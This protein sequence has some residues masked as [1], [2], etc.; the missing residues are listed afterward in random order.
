M[1]DELKKPIED[2]LTSGKDALGNAAKNNEESKAFF[3]KLSDKLSSFAGRTVV[4]N[5]ELKYNKDYDGK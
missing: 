5:K 4:E 3:E 1:L 2:F